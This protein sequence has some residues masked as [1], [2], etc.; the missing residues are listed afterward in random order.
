MR[1]VRNSWLLAIPLVLSGVLAAADWPGFR[2][3]GGNAVTSDKVPTEWGDKK[4]IKWKLD[5]PGKGFSS[6][7]VVG[8]KVFVTCY[9]GESNVERSLVCV[10]RDTGKTLWTKSV[11]GTERG[12]G[13]FGG[14]G[15]GGGGRGMGAQHGHASHTPVSDGERVYVFF[16]SSGVIAYDMK[17]EKLWEKNVGTGSSAMFGS[18][19]SPIL[20]NDYLIV[21]AA[22]ESTSIRAL[23]KKTG[24]E[25]WNENARSLSS[26]YS[27][28]SI[29]K[30]KDGEDELVLSATQEVWGMNPKNGKLKWYATTNVDT[31]S[32]TSL[33][34]EGDVVYAVGGRG[35]ARAAVRVGGKND[36]TS[37]NVLWSK[38]GGSYVGSPVLYK[39]HLYWV[40][41]QGTAYCVDAKTGEQAG[42]TRLGGQYYASAVVADGKLY[43]VSRFGGTFVLE[44]NPGMKEIAHNKL[45]DSSDFSGSP[46]VSNGQLFIRSDRALYC[47][48]AE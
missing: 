34:T 42:R 36:A 22:N 8:D 23:D 39:G 44:A 40:D 13:G 17:G 28:P 4:N 37:S 27:T 7:I 30:N 21:T 35:G 29:V 38:R 33:V 19:S 2:G 10:S 12:R 48:A 47:I 31:A 20:W 41:Q 26:C 45:S 1:S 43:I 32:C 6:P 9:S 5:L 24:K 16:G 11:K 14:G 46:A 15:G 18:A 3:P 25:V